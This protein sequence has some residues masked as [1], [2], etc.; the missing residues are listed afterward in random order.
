M[1]DRTSG[2]FDPHWETRPIEGKR[3]LIEQR[4]RG[5]LLSAYAQAPAIKQKLDQAGLPPEEIRTVKDLERV[6]MTKKAE[7]VGI[8]RENPPFGGLLTLPPNH[9]KRIFVS[10]GP[11]FDP[12]KSG[13]ADSRCCKCLYAAGIRSGDIVQNTFMYHF[14]PFGHYFDDALISM[15]CTV[16][17]AGGGNTELQAQVM[18]TLKVNGYIGTPSFLKTILD[19]VVEFGFDLQKDLALKVAVVGAEMLS[20][21]LRQDFET[22]VDMVVS[23]AYGTAD[24]G[25]IGHE[26]PEKKGYHLFDEELLFEIVDPTNGRQLS[27][28]EIGELVVTSFNPVYPLLRFGTGDLTSIDESPCACGR[29][30]FR[31]PRLLGRVDQVT[32]VRGMFIHPS[33]VDLVVG[34]TP[35]I[36]RCQVVVTQQNH[37]DEMTFVIELADEGVDRELLERKLKEDIREM[38]RLRGEIQFV[39]S[40]TI[41]GEAKTIVDKRV[42]D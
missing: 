14:T 38:M 28:G 39:P 9:L 1:K 21:A 20:E 25:L 4:L 19:K 6:P 35:L 40:G 15:D 41:P 26:C 33:Q 34:K 37:Q 13:T 29:T 7:L 42:W 27:N 10:P 8:Q 2:Y 22:K 12:M 5:T 36:S 3:S 17:P 31:L 16:I 18:Q 30:S 11:I 23:Q 24:V 32:K